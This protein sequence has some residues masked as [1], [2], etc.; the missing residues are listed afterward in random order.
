[1]KSDV[2]VSRVVADVRRVR[3]GGELR[4][5][6]RC[7][8][9][10]RLCQPG[11]RLRRVNG[12]LILLGWPKPVETVPGSPS[13]T[14]PRSAVWPPRPLRSRTPSAPSVS[15]SPEHRPRNS[16]PSRSGENDSLP[17]MTPCFCDTV[18]QINGQF[19]WVCDAEGSDSNQH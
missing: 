6:R 19:Y 4:R 15:S 9:L 13:T 1:V 12:F 2:R 10:W 5:Q 18:V 8:D 11:Q 16:R 14:R 3:G 7:V 17:I